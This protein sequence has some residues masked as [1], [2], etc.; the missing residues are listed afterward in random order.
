MQMNEEKV[1]L[2]V[3]DQMEPYHTFMNSC[4]RKGTV[5]HRE[6]CAR[7]GGTKLWKIGRG[8]KFVALRN[9]Y[10]SRKKVSSSDGG[11]GHQGA[12]PSAAGS[13]SS[14]SQSSNGIAVIPFHDSSGIPLSMRYNQMRQQ[15]GNFE[16]KKSPIQGMGIFSPSDFPPDSMLFEY[17]GEIIR[18]SVADIREERYQ[19]ECIGYYMF[20]FPNGDI[21][22]A[23]FSGSLSR[24]INH[25][26]NVN[27]YYS[28]SYSY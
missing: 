20:S 26:H 6:H 15:E 12:P 7:E 21:I 18:L 3:G 16:I 22:D 2:R 10:N 1:N 24:F 25:S 14:L 4:R 23:T 28:N 5:L 17:K 9:K 19:K 27:N 8:C 11:R 13:S